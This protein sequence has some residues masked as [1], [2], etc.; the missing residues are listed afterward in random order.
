MEDKREI[1][2]LTSRFLEQVLWFGGEIM[3]WVIIYLRDL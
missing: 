3:N 2:R 1:L